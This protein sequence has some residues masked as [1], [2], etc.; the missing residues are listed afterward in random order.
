[1][2]S[3]TQSSNQSIVRKSIRLTTKRFMFRKQCGG[4]HDST[5]RTQTF[6][7]RCK[8]RSIWCKARPKDPPKSYK[9]KRHPTHFA[10]AV[11][12]DAAVELSL[13]KSKR[14]IS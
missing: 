12:Q 14:T 8:G 2:A 7:Q 6:N 13:L 3:S 10:K 1:M 9:T 5:L 4:L 11:N